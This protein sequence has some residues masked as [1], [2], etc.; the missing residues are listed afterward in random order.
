MKRIGLLLGG[1]F[2]LVVAFTG[3]PQTASAAAVNPA[4]ALQIDRQA[5]ALAEA[6]YYRRHYHA[7]HYGYRHRYYARPY[8]YHRAY[9]GRP[10]AYRRHYYARPYAYRRAYYGRP[11]Y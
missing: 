7:R 11:V 10:Y 4:A 1:L 8:A 6:T 3:A 9:Y 5:P 2:A